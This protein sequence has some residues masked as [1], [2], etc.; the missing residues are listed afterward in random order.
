MQTRLLRQPTP[1]CSMQLND[2]RAYLLQEWV[3]G[4][5]L[6]EL[7]AQKPLTVLRALAVLQGRHQHPQLGK[8]VAWIPLPSA[9]SSV[10]MS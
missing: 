6:Q 2:W 4:Y 8:T 7:L 3:D 10:S 5:S 9:R 1:R